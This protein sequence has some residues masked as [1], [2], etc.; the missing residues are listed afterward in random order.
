M[1]ETTSPKSERSFCF[2]RGKVSVRAFDSERTDGAEWLR[3]SPQRRIEAVEFLRAG[4]VG[5]NYATQRLSRF[6]GIARQA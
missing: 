1:S 6:L 4:F 5:A 2:E 3:V